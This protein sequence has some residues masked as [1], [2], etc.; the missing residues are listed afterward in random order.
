[1]GRGTAIFIILAFRLFILVY[2]RPGE[3]HTATKVLFFSRA[4]HKTRTKEKATD[5]GSSGVSLTR[6]GNNRNTFIGDH[7]R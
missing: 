5:W 6:D 3:L 1:M 4:S 7:P 2:R